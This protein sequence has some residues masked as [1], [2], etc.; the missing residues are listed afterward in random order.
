M[1][2]R[3]RSSTPPATG[4]QRLGQAMANLGQSAANRGLSPAVCGNQK[5]TIPAKPTPACGYTPSTSGAPTKSGGQRVAL[6][7]NTGRQIFVAK[8]KPPE[9]PKDA[10]GDDFPTLSV[11][12]TANRWGGGLAKRAGGVP[13]KEGGPGSLPSSPTGPPP[14]SA[15]PARTGPMVEAPKVANVPVP[16][17]AGA[18]AASTGGTGGCRTLGLKFRR[19]EP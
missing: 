1:A 14:K 11:R 19:R 13:P 7:L 9:L 3:V 12:E 17:A 15:V 16:K 8:P 2:Q 6:K 5:G 10:Y 18:D 4:K